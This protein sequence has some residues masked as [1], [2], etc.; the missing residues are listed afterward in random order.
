MFDKYVAPRVK[1]QFAG[2][3]AA[4]SS[5]QG[6]AVSS[7]LNDLNL[8]LQ[9]QHG[10]LQQQRLFQNAQFQDAAYG[11]AL[12]ASNA[13]DPTLVGAG[14][15]FSSLQP[16]FNEFMRTSNESNPYLSQ[17]LGYISN[18]QS[19]MYNPQASTGSMLLGGALGAASLY[20]AFKPTPAPG[21]NAAL[22]Q[23]PVAGGVMSGLGGVTSGVGIGSMFGPVGAGVGGVLG[24]IAGLFT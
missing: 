3:G 14:N 9:Q 13:A 20:S 12:Q 7:A 21:S 17:A 10:Q 19:A 6:D 1:Q 16:M 8:N 23:G 2:S 5:R 15:L 24:G 22:Q 11:R 4:F 18:N